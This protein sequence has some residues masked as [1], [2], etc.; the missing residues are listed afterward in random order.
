LLL[1]KSFPKLW[2]RKVCEIIRFTFYFLCIPSFA[3]SN[4]L[5]FM[6]MDASFC[7]QVM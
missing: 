5:F 1:H 7:L 3:A 6:G 4:K 2:H